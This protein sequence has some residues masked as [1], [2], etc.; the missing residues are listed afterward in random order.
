MFTTASGLPHTACVQW[1][2]ARCRT[3]I[4]WC[5]SGTR[6][7]AI[8]QGRR[9]VTAARLARYFGCDAISWLALQAGHDLE[10][11]TTRKEIER[12]VPARE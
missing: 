9:S 10:T 8:V 6:I 2:A 1:L 4:A 3:R 12:N 11:L 7:H 5:R